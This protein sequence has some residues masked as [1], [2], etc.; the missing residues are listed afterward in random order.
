MDQSIR[1]WHDSCYQAFGALLKAS[2]V[3]DRYSEQ[4][5]HDVL[6]DLL[7]RF[8]VWAGNIG[9][10]QQGRAS[11]DYRLREAGT[12]KKLSSE[13]FNTCPKQ[14]KMVSPLCDMS[15]RHLMVSDPSSDLDHLRP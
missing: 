5:S 3:D 4:L 2:S 9:A 12:S 10:G 14:L 15:T 11:L 6:I 8:N 13:R 1:T 7:G